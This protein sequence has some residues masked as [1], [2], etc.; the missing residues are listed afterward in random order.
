MYTILQKAKTMKRRKKI[1]SEHLDETFGLWKN[2]KE[3]KSGLQYVNKIRKGW[4]KRI[5][6]GKSEC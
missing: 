2:R 3:I 6:E 1:L 4:D 5:K